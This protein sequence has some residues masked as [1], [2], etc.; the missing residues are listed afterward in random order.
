MKR[1]IIMSR[2]LII[3]FM[4]F[5]IIA[6]KK[7]KTAAG[8]PYLDELNLPASS[9]LIYT[10]V[11]QKTP[12]GL[13]TKNKEGFLMYGPYQPFDANDYHL[14]I[15]GKVLN[16]QKGKLLIV[17]AKNKGSVAIATSEILMKNFTETET[18]TDIDLASVDFSLTEPVDDLEVTARVSADTNIII[19]G[20][21]I[22][23]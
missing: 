19:T 13:V 1:K 3:G 5:G 22:S 2:G 10:Q 6:C 9:N 8:V 18:D 20:Y 17:I 21:T 7:N 23:K 16:N 12:A 15:N 11:G 4:V 14:T